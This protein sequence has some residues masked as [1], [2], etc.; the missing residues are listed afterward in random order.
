[1]AQSNTLSL[2]CIFLRHDEYVN[3]DYMDY[4]MR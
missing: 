1:M 4:N 2:S 3:N